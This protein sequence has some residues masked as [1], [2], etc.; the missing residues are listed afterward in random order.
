MIEEYAHH[1]EESATLML[2]ESRLSTST[3]EL[4]KPEEQADLVRYIEDMIG[5]MTTANEDVNR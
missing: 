4:P 5:L 1:K 2:E 3:A